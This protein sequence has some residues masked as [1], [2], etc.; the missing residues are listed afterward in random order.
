MIYT[1]MIEAIYNQDTAQKMFFAH[2]F[3]SKLDDVKNTIADKCDKELW[4]ELRSLQK[5]HR[6][7]DTSK[8]I[9][10]YLRDNKTQPYVKPYVDV[11]I[12]TDTKY[13]PRQVKSKV[14]RR[15][16]FQDD[17]LRSSSNLSLVRMLHLNHVENTLAKF[18]RIWLFEISYDPRD[19]ILGRGRECFGTSLEQGGDTKPAKS[20]V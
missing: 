14:K 6:Y 13:M 7:A 5:N 3:Y 12:E 4:K 20:Q 10:K 17:L 9:Y 19:C 15:E 1:K 11:D 16:K 2:G 18:P 8:G